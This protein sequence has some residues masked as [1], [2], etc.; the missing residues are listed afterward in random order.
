M[1]GS[2]A[3]VPRAAGGPPR[4][5]RSAARRPAEVARRLPRPQSLAVQ[6]GEQAGGQSG[7]QSGGQGIGQT[8]LGK[9]AVAEGVVAKLAARASL[10]VDGVGAA[11]TRLL[12]KELSGGPLDKLGLKSSELGAL[13]SCSAQVD[14]SLAFVELTISVRYP[15]P[16]RQVAAAVREQVTRKVGQMAGVQVVEV[17]IKVPAL[18]RDLPRS[19]RVH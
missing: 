10:E 17:D 8:E 13:P 14:G 5:P 6:A 2:A 19:Q 11:A 18:V 9:I 4:L 3:V 7:G 1:A 12:G 15:A 16:V